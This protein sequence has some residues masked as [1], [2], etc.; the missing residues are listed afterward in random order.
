M[1]IRNRTHLAD[2]LFV[3]IMGPTAVPLYAEVDLSG[4]WGPGITKTG[5]KGSLG[6][7]SP[8]TLR[9][10]SMRPRAQKR[11]AG[12][13]QFRRCQNGNVFPSVPVFPAGPVHDEDLG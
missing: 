3:I 8:I 4:Q 9:Y 11:I 6:P 7:T 13:L 2:A 5:R 10:P 1:N 12:K